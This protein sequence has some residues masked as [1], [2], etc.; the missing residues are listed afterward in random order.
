MAIK[1]YRSKELR[2]INCRLI[3]NKYGGY[4]LIINAEGHFDTSNF[5]FR[6][7]PTIHMFHRN[8]KYLRYLLKDGTVEKLKIKL[9]D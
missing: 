1:V 6:V 2:E 7:P 3:E 4:R 5:K 8:R 9:V